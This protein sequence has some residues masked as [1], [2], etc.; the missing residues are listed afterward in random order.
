M[1]EGSE[2]SKSSVK[3]GVQKL[4]SPFLGV[5]LLV[6]ICVH[7]AG[8]LI[9]RVVSNPLPV[10]SES[11][12]F[13]QYVSADTMLAGAEF[14]EQAALFDSSP[15]FIPGQWNAAHNLQPPSRDRALHRFPAYVPKIDFTAAL[16]PG[17]LVAQKSYG[18][19]APVDLLALQ[20]WDLFR[21]FGEIEKIPTSLESVGIF[22]EVR[23]LTGE[24][25]RTVPVAMEQ[26]SLQAI[27][28]VSYFLRVE[29]V[30]R[31]LGRPTLSESSGDAAFDAAAYT[32]LV[33]S[34]FGVDLPR[35]VFEIR[36]YP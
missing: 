13:V 32:Y 26:V 18:V 16:A 15:L 17:S 34:G 2:Q 30:G 7:L 35:G 24:V 33:E 1:A 29:A 21:G 6:G 10:R 22:A 27:Q 14:E 20:Y 4:L 23:T 36:V 28:P 9:F 25:L 5:A 12:P 19:K 8:F 11:Q 3:R 31:M